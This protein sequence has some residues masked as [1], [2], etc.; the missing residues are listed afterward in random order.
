MVR[1]SGI[2]ALA[3]EMFGPILHIATFKGHQLDQVVQDINAAGYG[4]TLGMH[5]RI[6]SRVDAVS[7]AAHIGNIYVNR[8]QIGAI[9]G[10]QPFGGH[11]L[12]GTG[13]KA[14][15]AL[16]L[17]KFVKDGSS[18]AAMDVVK[19]ERIAAIT[20]AIP[21]ELAATWQRVLQATTALNFSSQNLPSPTGERNE[22]RQISRGTVACLGGLKETD[23]AEQVLSALLCG[24]HIQVVDAPSWLSNL[25]ACGNIT[26]VNIIDLS[27]VAAI[28]LF[29]N[30][31]LQR[32][33]Q[34]KLA[35]HEGIVIPLM[36][37][38]YEVTA[39]VH[40]VHVCTDTTAAGG[41]AELLAQTI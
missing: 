9:V 23:L 38:L 15:G 8:N 12:S 39:L 31:E 34:R 4:L 35:Q 5:S 29:G 26:Q 3:K 16:Y 7:A 18:D 37:A 32:A 33:W 20:A 14:G 22:Y 1:V 41:N 6:E 10:S 30:A 36:T 21:A 11:G 17:S 25:K 27:Q 28:A 24:N 40:E 2:S 19:A 13:P